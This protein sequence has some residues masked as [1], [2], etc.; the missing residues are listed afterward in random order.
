MYQNGIK[1]KDRVVLPGQ[2]HPG[3]TKIENIDKKLHLGE[4]DGY[5]TDAG[6]F[7]LVT[8]GETISPTKIRTTADT[9]KID[10]DLLISAV[11]GINSGRGETE[12]PMYFADA[13][14]KLLKV[15][16]VIKEQYEVY[17]LCNQCNIIIDPNEHHETL[18]QGTRDSAGLRDKKIK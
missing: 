17:T 10:I 16:E 6:G 15:A 1:D 7:T 11:G 9:E 2:G 4:G 3:H 18:G 8:K 13:A 12:K 5:E 14:D